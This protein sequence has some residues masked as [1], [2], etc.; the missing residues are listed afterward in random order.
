[1]APPAVTTAHIYRGA[2]PFVAI[3]V[4]TLL[5][6]AAFPALVTWLPAKIY[7]S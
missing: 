4:L 2:I 5:V 6:I 7:G 1:V 3:Q